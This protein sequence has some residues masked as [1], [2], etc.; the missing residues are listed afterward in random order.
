MEEGE[1]GLLKETKD[2]DLGRELLFIKCGN[3]NGEGAVC[4]LEMYFVE[5]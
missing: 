4:D 5:I 1:K 2:Q 3:K